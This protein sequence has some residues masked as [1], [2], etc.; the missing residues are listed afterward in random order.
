MDL[1]QI[2]NIHF[3]DLLENNTKWETKVRQLKASVNILSN[4]CAAIEEL[5]GELRGTLLYLMEEEYEVMNSMM[6]G[7]SYDKVEAALAKAKEVL[8]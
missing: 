1:E 8:G 7:D 5:C 2:K 6:D 3:R 4:K